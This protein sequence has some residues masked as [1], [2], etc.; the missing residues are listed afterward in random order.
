MDAKIEAIKGW[1]SLLSH[2]MLAAIGV[3]VAVGS[4]MV[5][6]FITGPGALDMRESIDLFHIGWA[7]IALFVA[8]AL[9]CLGGA[10][11]H[12]RKLEK[13]RG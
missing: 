4:G 12:L 7:F 13:Y 11:Y 1:V 2:L 5:R 10:I 9:F 6:Y 8:I 3:L